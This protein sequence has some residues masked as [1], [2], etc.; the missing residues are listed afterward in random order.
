[1]KKVLIVVGHDFENR[2]CKN[3]FMDISEYDVVR[4]IGTQIFKQEKS[5]KFDTILKGRNT[6]QELPKEIN[7]LNP[8]LI[9]SIHLNAFNE[10]VQ[11]T[12]TLYWNTSEIGKDYAIR[13]QNKLVQNLG[14]NDRGVKPVD[15]NDRGAHLLNSTK[16]PCI[17]IEPFF[18]DSIKHAH[19]LKI[20]V[21]KTVDAVLDTLYELFGR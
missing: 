2:G 19:D 21:G 12:E 8:D 17:L 4:E 3:N 9:I 6:Y 11:G 16:A 15:N 1:M 13:F 7:S 18:L 10:Q 14:F 5:K 20:Y